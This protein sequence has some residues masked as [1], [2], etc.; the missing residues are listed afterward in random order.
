VL[1]NG[2]LIPGYGALGCCIAALVSEWIGG[3]LLWWTASRQLS[4]NHGTNSMLV[5]LLAG[6][7]MTAWFF[8]IKMA[9]NN[10]WIILAITAGLTIVLLMAKISHFKKYFIA[11]R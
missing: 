10:V 5:Y 7:A 6:V 11:F 8:L 9:V 3:M 4:L 1:L 2:F